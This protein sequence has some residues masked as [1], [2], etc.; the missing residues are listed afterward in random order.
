MNHLDDEQLEN[1]LRAAGGLDESSPPIQADLAA[2]VKKRYRRRQRNRILSSVVV[3]TVL[4]FAATIPAWRPKS[5]PSTPPNSPANAPDVA[6]EELRRQNLEKLHELEGELNELKA[7]LAELEQK[8]SARRRLP[9]GQASSKGV[10]PA[11]IE[12]LLSPD[13]LMNIE[14]EKTAVLVLYRAEQYLEHADKAE[15][16]REYRRILEHFPK[17]SSA[18]TAEE[19]VAKLTSI[20]PN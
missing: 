18:K 7:R 11:K 15:A 9:V 5:L 10:Q 4:L 1:I 16:L 20:Y 2:T 17:T 19:Q 8:S 6:V 12:S 14:S 3:A 13:D